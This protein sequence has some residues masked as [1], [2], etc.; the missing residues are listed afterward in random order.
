V[1][2]R[3]EIRPQR[4]HWRFVLLVPPVFLMLTGCG[5]D[6]TPREVQN[7]RA[8]ESL[9]TAISLRRDREVDKDAKLIDERHAAGEISDAKYETPQRSPDAICRTS[10]RDLRRGLRRP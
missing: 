5:A 3:T 9:L 2:T 1:P 7:A 10:A 6:P 4:R 8:F